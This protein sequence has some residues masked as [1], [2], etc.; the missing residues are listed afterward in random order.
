[1]AVVPGRRPLRLRHLRAKRRVRRVAG[2]RQRGRVRAGPPGRRRPRPRRVLPL[3]F[4]RQAVRAPLL[5]GE[6]L[7]EG[8]R[9]LPADHEDG[10]VGPGQEARESG[11]APVGVRVPDHLG[12]VEV[13]PE[14]AVDVALGVRLV[15]ERL[16]EGTELLVRHLVHA[17]LERARDPDAVHRALVRDVTRLAR[18]RAHVEL[19][20]RD[21]DELHADRVDRHLGGSPARLRSPRGDVPRGADGEPGQCDEN[22]EETAIVPCSCSLRSLRRAR[23]SPAP[24]EGSPSTRPRRCSP[25]SA[26]PPPPSGSTRSRRRRGRGRGRR[27][28]PPAPSR[29]GPSPATRCRRGRRSARPRRT[30]RRAS[31][32]AR[33]TR[34]RATRARPAPASAGS[35]SPAPPRGGR[36]G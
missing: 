34:G 36:R 11:I 2:G 13:D 5:L 27:T 33:G 4:R 26:G 6:P 3:G 18:R 25:C 14:A 28:P 10:V 24:R 16:G 23:S 17:H 20:R 7:A 8:L 9:V 19:P 29:A 31:R 32:T 12:A 22:G 35:P 30:R 21:P 1:M 15:G